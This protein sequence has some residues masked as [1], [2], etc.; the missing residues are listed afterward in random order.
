[1]V[2]QRKIG[3]GGLALR[4][5]ISWG[6]LNAAC[7]FLISSGIGYVELEH[8]EKKAIEKSREIY[9]MINSP[10]EYITIGSGVKLASWAYI[11]NHT[12]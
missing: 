10:L 11:R 2:F 3:F 4:A 8:G 12:K 7:F 9:K 1:M 5:G 6:L